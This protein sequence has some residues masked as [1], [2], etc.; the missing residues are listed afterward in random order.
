MDTFKGKTAVA[1]VT[2]QHDLTVSEVES[3]FDKAQRD[4]ENELKAR[5]YVI[6]RT[7]PVL[8]A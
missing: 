3:W 4:M 1:E 6:P 8:T 2:R 7:H 5:R